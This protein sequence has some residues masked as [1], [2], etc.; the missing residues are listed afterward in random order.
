MRKFIRHKLQKELLSPKYIR[1]KY[2]L[3]RILYLQPLQNSALINEG[4]TSE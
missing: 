3:F 1:T 4:L 2:S